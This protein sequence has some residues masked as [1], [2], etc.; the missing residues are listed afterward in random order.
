MIDLSTLEF[1]DPYGLV[2][3]AVVTAAAHR[4][5]QLRLPVAESVRKYLSRMDLGVW[6][7]RRPNV[8]HQIQTGAHQAT[9]TLLFPIQDF[10]SETAVERLAD[11]AVAHCGGRSGN[12]AWQAISELGANAIQH[13]G[14][15]GGILA[16]Q[17]H[18]HADGGRSA[19]LAIGDLGIGIVEHMRRIHPN[20][21]SSDLV[22][23]AIEYGGTGVSAGG[24][25]DPGRGIGLA[26]TRVT[27]SKLIVRCNDVLLSADNTG[28]TTELRTPFSGTIVLQ[29]SKCKGDKHED[30]RST[31]QNN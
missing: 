19:I 29:S 2:L 18:H 16:A 6:L 17:G 20:A 21:T 25:P 13:S 14:Q 31:E 3:I 8:Q 22:R 4:P 28:T 12:A 23:E 24:S 10:S 7:D 11:E 15:G 27:A 1:V 9:S 5:V 30:D 26:D